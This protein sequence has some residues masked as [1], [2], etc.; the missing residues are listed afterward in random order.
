MIF[1]LGS[2]RVVAARRARALTAA[3]LVMSPALACGRARSPSTVRA[4]FHL[5]E[6]VGE[7]VCRMA[8]AA[9]RFVYGVLRRNTNPGSCA[10]NP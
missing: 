1:S 10:L 4:H 8:G 6:E 5:A 9:L 3:V 2:C 7:L